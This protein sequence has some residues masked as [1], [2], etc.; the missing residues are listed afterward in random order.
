M[1]EEIKFSDILRNPHFNQF[2]ALISVPY[3]SMHWRQNHPKVPFWTRIKTITKLMHDGGLAHEGIRNQFIGEFS[4]LIV[5]LVDADPRLFYRIEDMDWF[6]E[7]L[8]GE[9]A[10]VTMSMLFAMASSKQT[11]LTPAQIAEATDTAESTWRNKAAAGEII[12]AFK[13]G[14]QWLIPTTSLRAYGVTVELDGQTI[15]EDSEEDEE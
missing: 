15:D 7:A 4:T 9:Y 1:A 10:T 8:S 5:E 2:V 13:A 11:Y 14:K 3:R 6:V 12:G